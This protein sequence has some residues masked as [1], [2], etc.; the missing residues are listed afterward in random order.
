[1]GFYY[2]FCSQKF[3]MSTQ[4]A[5]RSTSANASLVHQPSISPSEPMQYTLLND[6]GEPQEGYYIELQQWPSAG[7]KIGKA[8]YVDEDGSN[9]EL[10]F[11]LDATRR[12]F[13]THHLRA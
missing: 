10:R 5:Y 11:T 2:H 4:T 1:M 9:D 8:V 13:K 3:V 6:S 12:V 7:N